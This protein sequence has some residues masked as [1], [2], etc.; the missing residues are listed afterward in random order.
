MTTSNG[1][2]VHP[3]VLWVRLRKGHYVGQSQTRIESSDQSQVKEKVQDLAGKAGDQVQQVADQAQSQVKSQVDQR[4]TQVGEQIGSTAGD[5]RSVAEEL[6]NRDKQQPAKLADQAADKADQIA[7]YLKRSDGQTILRDVEDFGR[8]QPWAVVA[9][10]IAL[11]FLA[12]RFLKSSSSKRYSSGSSDYRGLE[13]DGP[14]RSSTVATHVPPVD[15][16]PSTSG[17]F[18]TG[19]VG[20]TSS[21]AFPDAV[22]GDRSEEG[23]G[24]GPG[25]TRLSAPPRPVEATTPPGG[26]SGSDAT[27]AA[28]VTGTKASG[29]VETASIPSG[30]EPS[31]TSGSSDS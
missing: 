24:A 14:A 19:G 26:P 6:R 17:A 3:I 16:T 22:P 11:G 2:Y 8:K 20:S 12:S 15:A 21:G 9:G 1:A 29:S 28:A 30:S 5:L 7:D 27:A 25:G 4:S 23:I 13:Y 31:G 10:G 18:T